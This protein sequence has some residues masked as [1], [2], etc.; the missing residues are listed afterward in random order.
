MNKVKFEKTKAHQQYK[1]AD[2]TIVPGVTTVLSIMAK[3]ALIHWAWE[4]GRAGLDYRKTKKQAADIGSIA[5]WLIEC[6]LKG[7]VPDTSEFAPADLDKAENAVIKFMSW[8][9][10]NK[11]KFVASEEQIT[12]ENYYYGG[13][14]DIIA[15]DQHGNICLV[16][17]KTS[18]GIYDE[19]WFQLAGYDGLYTE[20]GGKID[21]YII[22]RIGKDIDASDFEVQERTDLGAYWRV[23]QSAL[24]LYYALK[25]LKNAQS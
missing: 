6:Q 24:R 23:F 12:S 8:W 13:T 14:L 20:K 2:G 7:L 4:Q 15:E 1:L 25:G 3:P 16:D 22:C 19:Y 9:D 18:K 11:M 10:A 21:R 5:H 17:L